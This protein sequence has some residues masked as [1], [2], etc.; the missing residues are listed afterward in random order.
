MLPVLW[1][2]PISDRSAAVFKFE[3]KINPD[4]GTAGKC[5]PAPTSKL[6]KVTKVGLTDSTLSVEVRSEAPNKKGPRSETKSV[7]LSQNCL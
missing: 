3:S 2:G 7:G 1:C 4:A 6:V 5:E